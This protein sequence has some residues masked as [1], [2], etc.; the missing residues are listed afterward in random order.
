MTRKVPTPNLPPF[1]LN[2]IGFSPPPPEREP[3]DEEKFDAFTK[4]MRNPTKLDFAAELMSEALMGKGQLPSQEKVVEAL[5][6][7]LPYNGAIVDGHID[8]TRFAEAKRVCATDFSKAAEGCRRRLWDDL[9]VVP[10]A[11]IA[12]LVEIAMKT[13]YDAW[14]AGRDVGI[15]AGYCAGHLSGFESGQFELAGRALT[16]LKKAQE[17]DA[18]A[19]RNS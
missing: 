17:S 16:H 15:D 11:G 5:R 4:H 2:G 1:A 12:G 7:P 6:M 19:E 13:V 10:D 8:E 3:T 18:T 9:R 14:A